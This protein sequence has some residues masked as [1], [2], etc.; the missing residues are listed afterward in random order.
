MKY[1]KRYWNEPR[2]DTHNA[3]GFSWWFF[4][5]NSKG[6]VFRQVEKYD[7][8]RTIYYDIEHREDEFGG[9]TQTVLDLKEFEQFEINREEFEDVWEKAKS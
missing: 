8:G 7:S 6:E 3:W 1:F 5:T 4:E 9:L 2:G